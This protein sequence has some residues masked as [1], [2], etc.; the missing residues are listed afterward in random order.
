MSKKSSKKKKTKLIIKIGRAVYKLIASIYNVI[1]RYLITPV[2]KLLLFFLK[3]IKSSNKPFEILFHNKLF[4]ITFS[5][6]LALLVFFITDNEATILMNNSAEVLYNQPVTALYNEEAY[7]V[8]GLPEAVDITLIGRKSDL[9]LAKQYPTDDV[10]VDLRDLKP[11]THSVSLKYNG[12]VA[13]VDYKLDPST[14]TVVIYEKISESKTVAKEILHEEKLDSRYNITD[15]TFSRDEVYVKGAQYKLD[16]VA[17]VKALVD[18]NNIVNPTIGTTTLKDIPLVAYDKEGNKL[19]VEIVPSKLDATLDITSPSKEVPLKVIPEGSVVFGKAID[20]L[21]LSVKKVTIYGDEE[22]LSKISY[23][24]VKIDVEGITAKT[25]YN[26]NLSKPSG[27]KE[28]STS[29]VKVTVT[30]DDIVEKT[31]DG[32]NISTRNLDDGLTAKA[33]SASD[34][35]ISVIVKGTE[36]NLK[37]I[38]KDNITAYVDLQG[39]GKGTKTVSVNVTGDDLKLTYTSVTSTVQI[40]IK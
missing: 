40:V 4:L 18:V 13:S 10:V 36:S 11:G 20:E 1:D 16:Q 30:L 9:Y 39:L 32:V 38:T 22:A 2:T 6:V 3:L 19:A 26:I 8:E 34:S 24:P 12:S 25:D 31:I 37:N 35:T 33:A 29:T 15:I 5:L 14:A 28:L 27:I 23:L 7:V 17:V 21:E